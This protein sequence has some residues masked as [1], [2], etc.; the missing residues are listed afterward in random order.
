MLVVGNIT[1][2][3]VAKQTA[4]NTCTYTSNNLPLLSTTL[5]ATLRSLATIAQTPS[6]LFNPSD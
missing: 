1:G 3:G 5:L 2:E 4:S 6:N